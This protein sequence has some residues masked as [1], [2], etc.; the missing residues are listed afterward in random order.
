M[1]QIFTLLFIMFLDVIIMNWPQNTLSFVRVLG[2]SI[3]V[4]VFAV[5]TS[6]FIAGIVAAVI[7]F[8]VTKWS[9]AEVIVD[10]KFDKVSSEGLGF[11][12]QK[13]FNKNQEF[14]AICLDLIIKISL[15]LLLNILL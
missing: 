1:I 4:G 10:L 12:R 2:A 13:L 11:K 7:Y 8:F 15:L 6:G 9:V 5:F 3:F 14:R